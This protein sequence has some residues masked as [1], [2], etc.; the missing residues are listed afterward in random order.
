M[1]KMRMT[2]TYGLTKEAEEFLKENVE[3]I[4][5]LICPRC[6]EVVSYRQN[7]KIYGNAKDAGMFN[8]GPELTEYMLKDGSIVR[9]KLN[10]YAPWS[11]GPNLFIDLVDINGDILY[12]WTEKEINESI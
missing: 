9:E 10:K 6:E 12:G 4:P 1:N 2:Q 3:M 7:K 11:S 8:D 5:N